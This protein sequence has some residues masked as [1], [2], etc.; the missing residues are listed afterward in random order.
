MLPP[1]W[2][3]LAASGPPGPITAGC[4]ASRM[5]N[6]T[7]YRFWS[8]VMRVSTIAAAILGSVLAASACRA[9]K[10]ADLKPTLIPAATASVKESFDASVLPANWRVNKGDWQVKDGT[11][12]GKE[13]AE[14]MHAAVLT[15][16]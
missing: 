6:T 15:L 4:G 7:R 14:D 13:K 9:E 5:A 12:V 2:S 8:L 1:R 16:A 3:Q 10:N 11:I